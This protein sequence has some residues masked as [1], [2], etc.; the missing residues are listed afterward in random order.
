MWP[1]APYEVLRSL[2]YLSAPLVWAA[3]FGCSL[4]SKFVLCI[5][6]YSIALCCIASALVLLPTRCAAMTAPCCQGNLRAADA[7]H[8]CFAQLLIQVHAQNN[9]DTTVFAYLHVDGQQVAH[10]CIDAHSEGTFTG[11]ALP[12]NR[13]ELKELLFSLPRFVTQAEKKRAGITA[14][15]ASFQCISCSV[16]STANAALYKLATAKCYHTAVRGTHA[17]LQLTWM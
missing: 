3:N 16:C 2:H 5:S 17:L 6:P 15:T 4:C 8:C 12:S 7:L 1:V 14:V 10:I 11:A 9:S 13:Y